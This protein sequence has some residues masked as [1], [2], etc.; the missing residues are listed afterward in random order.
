M[1]LRVA[2][3]AT[4]RRKRR[5]RSIFPV[6]TSREFRHR[7][8]DDVGGGGCRILK[9]LR[10]EVCVTLRH[11]GRTVAEYLLH[12]KKRTV[13]QYEIGRKGVPQVMNPQMRQPGFPTQA[14]EDFMDRRVRLP[15]FEVD[16]QMVMAAFS[17]QVI[18]YGQRRVIQ[19]H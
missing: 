19:G 9:C 4:G 14:S 10:G 13:V 6:T 18:Q 8:G 16:E 7:V 3:G 15:G 1:E 17:I 2:S 12:L 5:F 11:D